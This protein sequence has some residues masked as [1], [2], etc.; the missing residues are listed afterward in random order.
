[1]LQLLRY[2]LRK[3]V[4]MPKRHLHSRLLSQPSPSIKTPRGLSFELEADVL[5][6]LEGFGRAELRD[7]LYQ[8]VEL[9]HADPRPGTIRF[10][11]TGPLSALLELRSLIAIYLVRPYA[12]PRPR[13]LLG[14][15]YFSALL[16]Q[17]GTVRALA[18]AGAYQTLRLSAAGADS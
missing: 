1:M 18:P 17:I 10:H 2:I 11:Y 6:G 4:W 8:Y 9:E 15:Q 12:V 16:D 7:R 5:E 3:T 13:A 14:H